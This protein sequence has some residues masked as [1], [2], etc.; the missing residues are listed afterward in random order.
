MPARFTRR[1]A[2][3]NLKKLVTLVVLVIAGIG[4]ATWYE[5]F[6][7][8]YEVTSAAKLACNEL[9]RN[10]KYKIENT[11][12]VHIEPFIR[13]C[14]QAG[15]RLK[16]N[17]FKFTPSHDKQAGELVCK[18]HIT[19]PTT[20]AWFLVGDIFQI[21]PLEQRKVLDFEHRVRDAY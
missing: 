17:Q 20:T 7:Q 15:V 3:G 13:R 16:P 11:D 5:P 8:G 2:N 1:A 14:T 9:V 21:P 10:W 6:A 18:V 4:V 12:G 19:Y